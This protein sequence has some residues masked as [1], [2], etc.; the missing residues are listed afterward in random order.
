MKYIKKNYINLIITFIIWLITILINVNF[1]K[2]KIPVETYLYPINSNS[3]FLFK[4]ILLEIFDFILLFSMTKIIQKIVHEV[5]SGNELHKKFVE[6]FMISF[7]ILLIYLVFNFPGQ[8]AGDSLHLLE[9]AR[10]LRTIPWHNIYTS[11]FYIISFSFISHAAGVVVFQYILISSTFGY[12]YANIF[13]KFKTKLRFLFFLILL[14][15]INLFYAN[16]VFRTTICGYLE[17]LTVFY[18]IFNKKEI[19]KSKNKKL[20]FALL[21]G[22]ISSYRSENILYLLFP[23]ILINKQNIKEVLKLIFICIISMIIINV[24]QK[25]SSSKYYNHDYLITNTYES[26]QYIVNSISDEEIEKYYTKNINNIIPLDYIKDYGYHS[27]FENNYDNTKHGTMIGKTKTEEQ[28]YLIDVAKMFWKYKKLYLYNKINSFTDML[29]SKTYFPT[30]KTYSKRTE[31]YF[32]EQVEIISADFKE[33]YTYKGDQNPDITK[34]LIIPFILILLLLIINIFK[35]K[36]N[37]FIYMLLIVKA[38]IVTLICP[39]TIFMYYY[40]LYLIIYYLLIYEILN[41]KKKQ[42]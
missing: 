1:I 38:L 40:F 5:K 21:V 35:K 29:F 16:W 36:A 11:L 18:I 25:I 34:K 26:L 33:K 8:W 15:P 42:I 27:Y 7:I 39:I 14:T 3:N 31:Y 30:G 2:N 9:Y 32:H 10:S 6:G 23:I 24:P 22:F 41:I 12:I 19:L 13:G 17:L 20:L 28:K 4:Y 37:M